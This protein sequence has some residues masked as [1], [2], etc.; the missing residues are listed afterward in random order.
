MEELV[1]AQA[2]F[3]SYSRTDADFVRLLMKDLRAAG[4]DTWIDDERLVPGT[5][6][7]EQAIRTAIKASKGVLFVATPSS[8]KSRFVRDELTI[9]QDS[10]VGIYPV[11]ASGETYSDCVPLGWGGI[12]HVDARGSYYSKAVSKLIET[13]NPARKPS[14]HSHF[15]SIHSTPQL[16]IFVAHSHNDDNWCAAL[17]RTLEE[18]GHDVWADH[19][20]ISLGASWA[21]SIERGITERDVFL[22]ALTPEA[23]AG[24]F[25]QQEIA[26]AMHLRKRILC[27]VL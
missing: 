21:K 26:L 12:Q 15:G 14:A 25:I 20:N 7:W 16:S 9:A 8:A 17:K 18:A 22:L 10:G 13:I 11:W 19:S 3:I 1:V 27:A 24:A 2:Y 4:I 23:W 6:D 5:P